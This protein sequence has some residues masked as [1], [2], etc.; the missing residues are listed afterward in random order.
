V[1]PARNCGGEATVKRGKHGGNVEISTGIG[2]LVVTITSPSFGSTVS[3]TIPVNA[4]LRIVDPVIVAGV[5][6]KLDGANLGAE[7]TTSP[8]SIANTTTASNGLSH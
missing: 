6:F 5:Q 2:S 4:R 7:D 1:L 8:Y 3:G